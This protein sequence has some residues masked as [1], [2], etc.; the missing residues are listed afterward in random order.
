MQDMATQ[1][2]AGL[3]LKSF[4]NLNEVV[5]HEIF[6]YFGEVYLDR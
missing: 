3:W 2:V 6:S 4:L 5:A 1:M